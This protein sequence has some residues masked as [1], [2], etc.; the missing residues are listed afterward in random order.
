MALD[1]DDQA[2][3]GRIES[4]LASADPDFARRVRAW[5]PAAEQRA[6]MPGWSALPRWTV[7]VFLIGFACWVLPTAVSAVVVVAVA[8]YRLWEH[9]AGRIRPPQRDVTRGGGRRR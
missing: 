3:L 8:G 4:D 1:A 7:E 6:P 5:R 2:R 9:V